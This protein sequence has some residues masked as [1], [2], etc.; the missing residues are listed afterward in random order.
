MVAAVMTLA[1]LAVAR[2]HAVTAAAHRKRKSASVPMGTLHKKKGATNL[3]AP[4]FIPAG[5]PVV[6]ASAV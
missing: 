2:C 4:D 1:G 6:L 3:D 5:L